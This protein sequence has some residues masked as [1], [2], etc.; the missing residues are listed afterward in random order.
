MSWSHRRREGTGHVS[1]CAH[2]SLQA[3][4]LHRLSSDA[5]LGAERRPGGGAITL[6]PTGVATIA[7][8][9]AAGGG[10][11]RDG[12]FLQ[13]GPPVLIRTPV[14][15][16][17]IAIAALLV[18]AA[19]TAVLR[20]PFFDHIVGLI[21]AIGLGAY[22]IVGI[23]TVALAR[24]QRPGRDLRRRRQCRR[25]RGATRR[26]VGTDAGT[27]A[28]R[29]TED[30]GGGCRLCGLRRYDTADDGTG[31]AGR[32]RG[33]HARLC[34]SHDFAALWTNDE[35]DRGLHTDKRRMSRVHRGGVGLEA[36]GFHATTQDGDT[37]DYRDCSRSI[38]PF[39]ISCR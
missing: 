37:R 14:Y 26:L 24:A 6:D 17:L 1:R 34:Q 16:I 10:L 33:H 29:I 4:A 35:A 38:H 30:P 20:I 5:H 28:T 12:I 18:I 22:A 23:A 19:G 7:L 25:W 8:V 32:I 39:R 9:T 27:L 21:D 2:W 31:S 13:V 15:I 36:P 11:L 3:A